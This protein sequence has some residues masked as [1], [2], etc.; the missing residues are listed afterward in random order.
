[1]RYH[2]TD[3][4]G[5]VRAVV[6]AQGVV[7]SRSDYYP[8]GTRTGTYAE[9]ADADGR[10]RFSGKEWLAEPAGLPLLD[11][12]A[13][14]YDPAT[15]SWLSQDP[16]AEKYP[17][18]SPYSYCAGDPVNLVDPDG[19]NWYYSTEDESYTYYAGQYSSEELKSTGYVDMGY[20]FTKDNKYYSLFGMVLDYNKEA[21]GPSVG[22][23]Y[24]KIDDLI[25]KYY[26]QTTNQYDAGTESDTVP[27]VD[28]SIPN[29]N[30]GMYS[31]NYVGQDFSS[32]P[33]GT[34]FWVTVPHRTFRNLSI[35]SDSRTYIER[36]P[37]YGLKSYG[38]YGQSSFDKQLSGYYIIGKSISRPF[39]YFTVRFDEIN[40][41]AFQNMCKQLFR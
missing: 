11:F 37:S 16:M 4:L 36:M 38:G 25:I 24:Q 6:D 20:T 31:F 28:F 2:I 39:D 9:A 34:Y 8:F 18:L 7:R 40:S 33:E 14:L 30:P 21:K 1:M 15:A 22:V 13:R 5:S 19:R 10:W 32:S 23:V 17:F 35:R 12:G 3:H 26:S 41:R 29:S 27:T